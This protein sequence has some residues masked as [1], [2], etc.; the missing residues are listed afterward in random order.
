MADSNSLPSPVDAV[1]AAAADWFAR[2]DRGLSGSEQAAYA[3][4]LDE[5]PQHGET[6][7]RL[8]LV[9]RTLNPVFEDAIARGGP[10]DPDL[11]A[12]AKRRLVPFWLPLLAA[13]AAGA[14]LFFRPHAVAPAPVPVVAQAIVHAAP[15][16]LVL[17]D[18]S[19]VD[20]KDS[21]QV[22]VQFTPAERRIRLIRGEAFFTV[23][24]NPARPFIVSADHITVRAVGTA[25]SVSLGATEVSVL[26]T[27]G[28]V[29]VNEL[30]SSTD[31]SPAVSSEPAPLAAGQKG[32][33]SRA[34]GSGETVAA[35]LKTSELTPDQVERALLWQGTRLEFADL[36]LSNIADAFNRFNR[37]QLVIGDEQTAAFRMGGSFR[38]DHVGSFVR[39]LVS[40][41]VTA[42]PQGDTLVL[43]QSHA[44]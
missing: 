3:T 42:T 7:A 40:F 14:V 1:E 24:K 36:P 39:V 38:A 22:D 8:E 9:W 6:I 43:R 5:N 18:G 16:R 10:A 34:A 23:A 19:T 41:G 20:L 29:G 4:W 2:R 31:G 28:R 21:A 15:E 30:S 11:L 32:V 27:E 13:A 12:P 37:I 35:K 17:A 44:R 25:F 33:I 26:V